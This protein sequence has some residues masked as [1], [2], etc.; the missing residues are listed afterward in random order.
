MVLRLGGSTLA[1]HQLSVRIQR[2]SGNL[3]H[4]GIASVIV[5]SSDV[6][7]MVE[8]TTGSRGWPGAGGAAHDRHD[9]TP[10]MSGPDHWRRVSPGSWE[11]M[12]WTKMT[13][14]VRGLSGSGPIVSAS[15]ST[16]R[17]QHGGPSPAPL[18]RL[19]PRATSSVPGQ[20]PRRPANWGKS[21]RRSDSRVPWR[22][23]V[24]TAATLA[25]ARRPRISV[26]H[27][28]YH[29]QDVSR[30]P[31]VPRGRARCLATLRGPPRADRTRARAAGCRR[32]RLV[33]PDAD[34]SSRRL[35]ARRTRRREGTGSRRGIADKGARR[36][37][38]G[39]ARRRRRQ[40]RDR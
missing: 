37:R 1:A 7:S 11:P 2:A 31:V 26:A 3:P 4:D 22:R 15:E 8:P 24:L 19:S 33:G 29:G 32:A 14:I 30:C 13:P 9:A 23:M 18:G 10:S 40:R 17:R 34:G 39:G 38:V 16:R 35:A 27:A 20:P 12:P 5:G 25:T 6:K 28:A 36:R 21:L